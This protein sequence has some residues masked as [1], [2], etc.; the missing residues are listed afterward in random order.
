MT[1]A[2]LAFGIW[3]YASLAMTLQSEAA[4]VPLPASLTRG[5]TATVVEVVD[6]DTVRL[7][8]GD[9]KPGRQ[10]RLVGTQGP[11][12]PLGRPNYPTWPLAPEARAH[13]VGLVQG[14]RVTLHYG[15]AREDRYGRILAH[16]TTED[17]TWIQGAML[18][19][20]F[21]RVYT[22]ADNR[23]A[24]PEMLALEAQAR[25]AK[26]GI[27]ANA[28]YR[29]RKPD[30]LKGAADSFQIVEGRVLQATA[31]R[32][33]AYLNFGA[34]YKTDF[35]VSIAKRDFKAFGRAFDPKRFANHVVRVRG[36][37]ESINGPAI[38]ATHPEQIEVL[39]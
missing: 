10:V 12:L 38:D 9:G 15:G 34:D 21:T 22:F 23:S 37:I 6:A 13:L 17:G 19:D 29:I 1:R 14:K 7:D 26:R 36:W 4:A 24:I 32:D 5:E 16:L 28:Y 2:L 31:T 25:A 8:D 27:W 11:K 30:D 20:G 33:R 3:I 18:A 39:E 35:T